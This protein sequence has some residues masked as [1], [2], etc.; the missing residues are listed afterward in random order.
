[1]CARVQPVCVW[2]IF[3]SVW[4]WISR[5]T[6][7][8]VESARFSIQCNFHTLREEG[9]EGELHGPGVSHTLSRFIAGPL[10]C[11]HAR[12]ICVCVVDSSLF[13]LDQP[14]DGA[15]EF[16]SIFRWCCDFHTAGED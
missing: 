12:A 1:V 2:S 9:E 14:A 10:V 4:F 5:L 15:A 7:L 11:V 6:V 16:G 8:K 3:K 13:G